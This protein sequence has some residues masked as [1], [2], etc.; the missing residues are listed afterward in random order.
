MQLRRWS[1][2][3]LIADPQIAAAI[4]HPHIAAAW[5]NE[6]QMQSWT[7]GLIVKLPR[8]GD[9]RDCGNWSGITLLNTIYKVVATIIQKR[10]QCIEE[11]LRDEQAG[12]RHNRSCVDQANT[13]RMIIEQSVKWRSPL[14]ML[15][16]Y[17]KKAFSSPLSWTTSWANWACIKEVWS[18]T[19][20]LEDLDFADDICL[21]SHKRADMQVK[22][23]CLVMLARS[24]GLETNITKTKD[25]RF[26]HNNA[27]YIIVFGCPVEFVESLC[28]LGCMMT[29]D[30]GAEEDVNCRL[31]KARAAFGRISQ[32]SRRTML[33]IFSL[34]LK[35]ILYGS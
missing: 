28:Y 22:A 35:P 9:L 25:M 32:I 30:G 23:D 14:Y 20:Q 26:N 34:C 7:K 4:L 12:F 13:L 31:D 24:V 10:L 16:V 1:S 6:E 21:L 15:F 3:I 17:F 33:R 8:K 27:N 18:F 5:E 19:R 29:T 11:S 2:E